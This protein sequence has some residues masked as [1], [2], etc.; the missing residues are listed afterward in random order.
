M[1]KDLRLAVKREYFEAIQRGEKLY[2]YREIKP[3]WIKRLIKYGHHLTPLD[4]FLDF[5][6]LIYNIEPKHY[7]TI[8]IT[9]GYPRTDEKEKIMVFKYN[10]FKAT[11]IKHKQFGDKLTRVFAISL[12]ERIQ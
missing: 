6:D 5:E 4:F 3:Y 1:A 10:G 7:D 2:E 8:T 11:E 12:R 9:L